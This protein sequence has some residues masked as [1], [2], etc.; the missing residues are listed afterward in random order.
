MFCSNENYVEA[1]KIKEIKERMKYLTSGVLGWLLRIVL[2][3][4][5]FGVNNC[6]LGN[7]NDIL[8]TPTESWRLFIS[9]YAHTIGI[10]R[11]Q[12]RTK[13]KCAKNTRNFF[14]TD[15]KLIPLPCL[16]S[17][18]SRRKYFQTFFFAK[19][20]FFHIRRWHMISI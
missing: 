7:Y 14:L 11:K 9:I 18:F 19:W 15:K 16:A 6:V 3:G 2:S 17:F 1:A 12:K 13:L 10:K 5:S 8:N 20:R 4:H